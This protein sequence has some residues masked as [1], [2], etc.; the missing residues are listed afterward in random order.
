MNKEPARKPEV[1]LL[2]ARDWV[3]I[4]TIAASIILA[5]F[6]AY[7]N[8]DRMLS[9]VTAIQKLQGER[10]GRLE[11]KLDQLERDLRDRTR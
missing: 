7:S 10:I 1:V 2:A 4:M 5:V 8:H 6:S 11:D 3:G 9:E